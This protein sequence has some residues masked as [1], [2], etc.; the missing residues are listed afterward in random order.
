[1]NWFPRCV[2]RLGI[3]LDL[4]VDAE[5][6]HNTREKAKRHYDKITRRT[7]EAWND[8]DRVRRGL[9]RVHDG[10]HNV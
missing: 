5:H 9:G 10:L 3:E 2:L 6:T 8:H 4:A 1:V 7:D